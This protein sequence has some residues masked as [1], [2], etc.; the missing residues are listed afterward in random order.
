MSRK[1]DYRA[2]HRE[3][4]QITDRGMISQIRLA[5]AENHRTL[6]EFALFWEVPG[7]VTN[8]DG[9]PWALARPYAHPDFDKPIPG[10]KTA[11]NADG[12][13][14][15]TLRGNAPADLKQRWAESLAK[16][17]PV[18]TARAIAAKV[19]WPY[20]DS[21]FEG[22]IHGNT[23]YGPVILDLD[24]HGFHIAIPRSL[25]EKP[26]SPV[27][28]VLTPFAEFKRRVRL[29]EEGIDNGE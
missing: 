25:E 10:F 3:I 13:L 19:G 26:W 21:S 6:S 14:R 22:I 23:I 27:N 5:C 20:A 28:A 12:S 7:Y 1:F 18:P 24:Q 4:Y 29:W 17:S 11:K 16:V 2:V 8:T 15:Y 9:V